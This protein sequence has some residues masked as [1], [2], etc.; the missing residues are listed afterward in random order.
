MQS[1]HKLQ[2]DF[3]NPITLMFMFLLNVNH[4]LTEKA[5]FSYSISQL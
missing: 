5:N 4:T 1:I 2:V 3:Y